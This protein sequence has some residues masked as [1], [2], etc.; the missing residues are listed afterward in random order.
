MRQQP[1][2]LNCNHGNLVGA[3]LLSSAHPGC[4][5]HLTRFAVWQFGS[6]CKLTYHTTKLETCTDPRGLWTAQG[7]MQARHSY[8]E[9]ARTLLA[10]PHQ[11][12][13]RLRRGAHH[14]Q[15]GVIKCQP[16]HHRHVSSVQSVA[17]HVA[18]AQP[19]R[20]RLRCRAKGQRSAPRAVRAGPAA[21][22]HGAQ[23]AQREHALLRQR[24]AGQQAGLLQSVPLP[25]GA[26]VL[27]APRV[28]G[29]Q[30]SLAWPRCPWH[31][32]ACR[33]LLPLE[34]QELPSAAPWLTAPPT[35]AHSQAQAP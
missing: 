1:L 12:C 3:G 25:C 35:Q 31:W 5:H 8:Q 18:P 26:L 9:P 28:G 29:R 32:L 2:L 21:R 24:A 23:Q 15:V 13:Q 14:C 6:C 33:Y 34:K 19:R 4:I 7:I 17:P 27:P 22:Q 16:G 30:S 20:L 11:R 10:R